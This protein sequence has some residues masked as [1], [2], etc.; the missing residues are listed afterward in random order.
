MRI[1][2]ELEVNWKRVRSG[3]EPSYERIESDQRVDKDWKRNRTEENQKQ[4]E[5]G[6]QWIS[7]LCGW[8][9]T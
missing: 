4:I 3:L 5:S 9:I 7:L 8:V 1:E 2:S 6:F